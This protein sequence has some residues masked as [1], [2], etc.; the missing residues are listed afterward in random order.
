MAGGLFQK[1]MGWLTLKRAIITLFGGTM[2]ILLIG[3]VAYETLET[4]DSASFCTQVCH[5]V[6]Y[7][8]AV[9]FQVSPHS[10][11]PCSRC[12][13][14]VGTENFVRS[15]I[16]G[17][18]DVLPTLTGTYERPILTPLEG[19]RP[20]SETC[21]K[22]HTPQKFSGDLVRTR[23][24][25]L[26]DET[27]TKKTNT[28]VLKVGGSNSNIA[29]GIHW[30][31][32]SDVWYLPMDEEH[33][34]IGWVGVEKDEAYKEYVNPTFT[35]VITSERIATEKRL[36]D[37]IDCHN[38]VSHL[39]RSPDELL[40]SALSDSSIDDSLPFI[41]RE[42]MK[43]IG[44]PSP[45]LQKAYA[46]AESLEDFYKQNYPLVYE[47]KKANIVRAVDKLKEII[48]LTSFPEMLVDW[49]TH[50][51]QSGHNRPPDEFMDEWNVKFNDWQTN[52]SEGCFRCHGT[53]IPI[54]NVSSAN[55]GVGNGVNDNS[56]LVSA[57]PN[58]DPIR[59]NT[60]DASCNLCHYTLSESTSPVPSSIPHPTEKLEDCL[61][62]HGSSSV[63]PVPEDH[64]WS[65]D[66]VCTTCH[67]TVPNST[68][69]QTETRTG[70]ASNTPH[71]IER[72]ED[73]LLC[74]DESA[75]LPLGSDHVWSTSETCIACHH[76]DTTL[77]P[78][79]SAREVKNS[80]PL[81]T[82]PIRGLEDCLLCH[83]KSATRSFGSNHPW[84]TND[85]CS[86]CH[87][88]APASLPIPVAS[89]LTSVPEIPHIT[90]GLENCLLCHNKSAVVPLNTNHPWSINET[91]NVCHETA[92]N[93]APLHSSISRKP[94]LIP[95][96]TE[97]LSECRLC[98]DQSGVR[99]YPADHTVVPDN[100]CTLCHREASIVLPP[101]LPPASAPSILHTLEGRQDCL[102]CH[103]LPGFEPVL[104][105]DHADWTNDACTSCHNP[106]N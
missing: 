32:T 100:F 73:C 42:A 16:H 76:L 35:G 85:T 37:C 23:S 34:E 15:K 65:T 99:P 80:I 6:H 36:M 91:C 33:L 50:A 49:T 102:S 21:E 93:L 45:G 54:E 48:K 38:R 104:P 3:F 59:K 87:K 9:T 86:T 8:E 13:V 44:T 4:V 68:L 61:L 82:H 74:H 19:R 43:A 31:V 77:L 55:V 41:K 30:H 11:V 7:P 57:L 1:I 78:F 26:P 83:D 72:L 84:S 14:G 70:F 81:L 17:L 95:H 103:E 24:V 60:L 58:N 88:A 105:A 90:R 56:Q 46:K 89:P 53:L 67:Q 5:D 62:C 63:K 106:A 20:S 98:H 25:Y 97:G 52:K 29:E 12:H 47:E 94:D 69:L 79:P 92:S 51:D 18:Q 10:E 2:G 22:C 64:P 75:P 96:I 66:E 39:F 28:V 101:S 27:N 71:P 40:D